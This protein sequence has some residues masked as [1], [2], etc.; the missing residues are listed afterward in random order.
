MDLLS[1]CGADIRVSRL[2]PLP[3]IGLGCAAFQLAC[4]IARLLA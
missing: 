1:F 2:H 4:R 3:D